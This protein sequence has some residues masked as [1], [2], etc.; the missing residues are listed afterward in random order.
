MA[1]YVAFYS[2]KGGVGRSLGLANVAWSLAARG[3]RVV[4]VDMDLEAPGLP[5]YKEFAI[6][7]KNPKGFVEYASAYRQTGKCPAIKSH[8]HACKESPGTGK[9]WLMP[10]GAVGGAYQ[11]QLAELSWPKLHP[12]KGTL[13]FLEAFKKA[14]DEEF[15]ADY[16]LIDSRTGLSDIGGLSTHQLADLVVLVFNLTRSCL[17]GSARTYRSFV[18]STSKARFLQLVACPIPLLPP[19]EGGIIERRLAYAREHMPLG[20][21]YGRTVLR[22]D[23]NPAMALADELAVRHPEAFQAAERYE[24]LREAIQR[25]NPEEVFPVLEQARELRSSGHFNEALA[26]LSSFTEQHPGNAEAHLELGNFLFEAGRSA[27]SIPAFRKAGELAPGVALPHRR[28][29]EALVSLRRSEEALAALEQARQLGDQGRELYLALARA[30]A[31]WMETERE[32]EARRQAIM[33]IL[34]TEHPAAAP[35]SPEEI[36]K[37]RREFL[38][39]L[40]RQPPYAS[41][42]AD[43]FWNDVMESLSLPLSGKLALLRAVLAGTTRVPELMSLSQI[44]RDE[45]ERWTALLGPTA[46]EFQRRIAE[47]PVDPSDG[48]AVRAARRGDRVDGALLAFL[49]YFE[50]S[51]R[52]VDLLEQAAERD[53]DNP[54]IAAALGQALV[55]HAREK[56]EPASEARRQAIERALR[57]FPSL[58]RELLFPERLVAWGEALSLASGWTEDEDRKKEMLREA[59]RHL[60][61]A[62]E[63]SPDRSEPLTQRG[64][65]WTQLARLAHGE[66]RIRLLR[67]ACRELGEAARKGPQNPPRLEQLGGGSR[68][69]RSSRGSRGGRQ[70]P[71][72]GRGAGAPGFRN[73]AARGRLQSGV[74][75]EPAPPVRGG[76]GNRGGLSRTGARDARRSPGRPRPRASLE[77]APRSPVRHR[78]RGDTLRESAGM[79]ERRHHA[80]DEP[81]SG[82]QLTGG[83]RSGKTSL[84]APEIRARV[85]ARPADR[86]R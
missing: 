71:G 43:A 5:E 57:I 67:E 32:T 44:L 47:G 42:R 72:R 51:D 54:A 26:L 62:S 4:L 84:C 27:D 7:G 53:P 69:P 70:P 39:T 48:D 37:L 75:A 82:L 68:S 50:P 25:A 80:P 74:C 30:H 40:G 59:D 77:R 49:A 46:R 45:D 76:R 21:A 29:G 58:P 85:R 23:Y 6:R 1:F 24:A 78:S 64:R 83:S 41:F 81:R 31:H 61:A 56:L 22:I 19:T 2:Y 73:R 18:S 86:R 12:Q 36:A 79:I 38:E 35:A 28:L 14:L 66:E 13:P 55:A 9:L 65:V 8:V 33:A 63:V 52:R 10:A 60:R 34:R 20:V 11:K 16:V 15:Q 3:K 17:E